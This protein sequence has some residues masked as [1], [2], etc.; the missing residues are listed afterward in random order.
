MSQWKGKPLLSSSQ[1]FPCKNTGP[2][3]IRSDFFL[4]ELEIQ[5][6]VQL[7]IVLDGQINPIYAFYMA[8]ELPICKHCLSHLFTFQYSL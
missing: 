7:K 8:C 1:L 6:F 5:I 3:V 2:D 4:E